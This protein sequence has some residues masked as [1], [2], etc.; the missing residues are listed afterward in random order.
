MGD[1]FLRPSTPGKDP[2]LVD[3]LQGEGALNFLTELDNCQKA[4]RHINE[5]FPLSLSTTMTT[6]ERGDYLDASDSDAESSQGYQSEEDLQK[7]ARSSKRRRIEEPDD[8]SEVDDYSN[9]D[10]DHDDPKETIYGEGVANS[11]TDRSEAPEDGHDETADDP[12][13]P[14]DP[15]KKVE[16]PGLPKALTKKNLVATEVAVKKSRVVYLSR[17]PPFMKPH[18]LRSLLEPYGKVNRIFLS[19]ES[20]ESRSRRLRN[21]GNRKTFFTE[22]W[23]EFVNKASAKAVCEILNARTIGGKKGSYYR[24]DVWT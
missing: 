1:I 9:E 5:P 6:K 10:D 16:L 11:R 2:T 13:K 19:P 15:D 24:D 17:I 12:E 23:V 8:D 20:D 3:P 21:G 22:G 14:T 4:S 18:K 7:G